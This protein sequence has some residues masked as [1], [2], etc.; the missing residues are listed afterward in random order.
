[1]SKS[2]I[3]WT[4]RTWNPVTGCTKV[5]DGCKHCYAERDWAR[6]KHLPRYDRPFTQV[7]YHPDR[8]DDPLRWQKPSKIFVCHNGDLFHESVPDDFIT[9]VF[10]VM[11]EAKQH[12]FQILTK[13]PDRMRDFMIGTSGCGAN[14]DP[15]PNIWY[16]VS[17]ENQQTFEER[18][19]Q[20]LQ[21]PATV[22]WLS[23]EP[24]LGPIDLTMALE[25][26]HTHN[27]FLERNP[28]PVQWIVVGG[29]S[30][31]KARPMHPNWVRSIRDQCQAA[32]VPF[33][34]KQWGEHRFI[35]AGALPETKADPVRDIE[36]GPAEIVPGRFVRCGKKIAGNTI[37]N[38]KWEEYP[39]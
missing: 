4:D 38:Q 25:Q 14:Y 16:G 24:M 33:F 19:Q 17:I 5:S 1:M 37:D 11:A 6:L 9:D 36:Y 18:Y 22:H 8:L 21:I 27:A 30:G 15:I 29:E 2:N 10:N 35:E 3:E 34:F 20:L 28:A 32:G 7:E 12:I 26:F 39:K 31:P 23:I 13:R